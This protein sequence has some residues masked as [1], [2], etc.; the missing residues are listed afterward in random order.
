MPDNVSVSPDGRSSTYDYGATGT[1]PSAVEL[2]D[3]ALERMSKE[4]DPFDAARNLLNRWVEHAGSMRHLL[5]DALNDLEAREK[6]Q[7]KRGKKLPESA[8]KVGDVA[9]VVTGMGPIFY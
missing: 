6:R 7:V 1:A 8:V 2:V 4:L 9:L 3:R 5:S